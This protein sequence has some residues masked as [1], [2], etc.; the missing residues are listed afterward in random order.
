M[1]GAF[2]RLYSLVANAVEVI[3]VLY[4]SELAT[5]PHRNY[6]AHP[7]VVDIEGPH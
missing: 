6:N 1:I 5:F 4:L 3:R 7:L 2:H